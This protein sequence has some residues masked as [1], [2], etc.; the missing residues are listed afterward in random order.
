MPRT[1]VA[2]GFAS[3][4]GTR[5]VVVGAVTVVI[6]T[7]GHAAGGGGWPAG[8]MAVPVVLAGAVAG[9]GLSRVAWT[10]ARLVSGLF[11]AQLV[12]HALLWIGSGSSTVDPRLAG[13]ATG[14]GAPQGHAHLT[15]S[16]TPHM[17]GGHAVAIVLTAVVLLSAER[18]ALLLAHLA[19]RLVPRWTRVDVPHPVVPRLRA[20]RSAVVPRLLHLA[21]VRGH[22]PPGSL[23]LT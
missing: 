10:A 14:H 4:Q 13:L 2:R 12:V 11:A 21:T 17:I 20:E 9:L 3:A 18:V 23:A 19:R 16:P 5:A 6:A 8:P 22:A 7:L 1:P 15:L